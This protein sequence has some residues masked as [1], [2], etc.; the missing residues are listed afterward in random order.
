MNDTK[1]L[2]VAAN[3]VAENISKIVKLHDLVGSEVAIL[4]VLKAAYEVNRQSG[5][6]LTNS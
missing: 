5:L 3:E 6:L 1:K 4:E 2:L